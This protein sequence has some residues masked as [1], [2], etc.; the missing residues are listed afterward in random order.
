MQK[1]K[2]IV[3]FKFLVVSFIIQCSVIIIDLTRWRLYE[4]SN[5]P[6][7]DLSAT[8]TRVDLIQSWNKIRDKHYVSV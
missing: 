3:S 1:I 4:K 6:S 5:L 2:R 8:N 7:A